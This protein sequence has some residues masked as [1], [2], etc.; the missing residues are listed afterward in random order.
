MEGGAKAAV[1]ELLACDKCKTAFAARS[2]KETGRV[3]LVCPSC[4]NARDVVLAASGGGVGK[5]L[6]VDPG[7]GVSQFAT[8]GELI[9]SRPSIIEEPAPRSG[10]SLLDGTP[11]PPAPKLALVD[12]EREIPAAANA[13]NAPNAGHE[14]EEEPISSRDFVEIARPKIEE[15]KRAI[16]AKTDRSD[17]DEPL[18]TR[19]FVQVT[20][21]TPDPAT[22]RVS[23]APPIP[24][25][26]VSRPAVP[27]DRIS[28]RVSR[29]AVPPDRASD[30]AS[31]PADRPSQ[32][33]VADAPPPPARGSLKTLPPKRPDLP[34]PSIDVEELL[35]SKLANADRAPVSARAVEA[36]PS[37]AQ[38]DKPTSWVLPIVGIVAAGAIVWLLTRDGSVSNE[39]PAATSSGSPSASVVLPERSAS[40]ASSALPSGSSSAS[41]SSSASGS[42][43]AAPTP[44]EETSASPSAAPAEPHRPVDIN[45]LSLA[46][47]LDRAGGARRGGDRARAKELYEKA[48]AHNPGNAEAY[49]GL[50]DLARAGGDLAGAKDA[51]Q[52]ALA[53]SP[54]YSPA[55]LGLAD[56]EW[57]MGDRASAQKRYTEIANRIGANA[58]V[59]VRERLGE[60][61]EPKPSEPP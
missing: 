1:D 53:T 54:S 28:D 57:E 46:E 42:A 10:S 47:L 13:E 9:G 40:P 21:P 22:T 41:P 39:V 37:V 18:S 56:I 20:R 26:R 6:L 30:R 44:A 36:R 49:A 29:P 12:S 25:D 43:A 15:A 38:D 24:P 32:Q 60:T 48:L 16:V 8:F 45:T 51:Y 50:G 34:P 19:D 23:R 2:S 55:L 3:Q 61:S 27:P 35:R 58:P 17:D 14:E 59:R 4:G 5:W 52:K 11:T 7:G 31:I 33:R